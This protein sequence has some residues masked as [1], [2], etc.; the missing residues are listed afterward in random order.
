MRVG[1]CLLVDADDTLWENNIYFERAIEEFLDLLARESLSRT[2]LRQVLDDVER[3]N[4]LV[5]G[6]GAKSF[7][8]SLHDCYERVREVRATDD[9]GRA[10]AELGERILRQE[11]V[12]IAG[13]EETLTG[14]RARHRLVLLTKGD[15]EEQAA[16]VERSRLGPL[17]E[18]IVIVPEKT[19]ETY[20]TVVADLKADTAR[21][22]MI[23]NSPK[24]DIVPALA[25][26]LGAVYVP[27]PDTWVLEHHPFPGTTERLLQVDRFTDLAEHF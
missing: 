24:S 23:G 1:Q 4:C 27:H 9:H 11:P 7:V 15:H 6:Y 2:E 17:F 19:V 10:I 21:T 20:A 12:L 18:R 25:A 22:W 26:G 3:E 13:V 16:K 8:R 5:Y 14:L